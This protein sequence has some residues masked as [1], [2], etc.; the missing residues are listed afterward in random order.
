M[1]FKNINFLKPENFNNNSAIFYMHYLYNKKL[2]NINFF[3]TFGFLYFKGIF[4][5]NLSDSKG[6][7]SLDI[8]C[9]NRSGKD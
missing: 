1:L 6:L 3:L 5:L 8:S 4:W 2:K 9:I 7:G